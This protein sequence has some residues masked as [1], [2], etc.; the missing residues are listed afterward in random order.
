MSW[1]DLVGQPQQYGGTSGTV[2]LGAGESVILVIAH[3]S[4]AGASVSILGGPAIPVVQGA[5]P[6][7]IRFNHTLFQVNSGNTGTIV[8]TGTDSY[9]VHSVKQGHA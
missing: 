2:T 5:P 7:S 4:G 1:Q 6:L 3:A 9:F 8:F